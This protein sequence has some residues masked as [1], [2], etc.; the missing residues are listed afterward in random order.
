MYPLPPCA[1][2]P[3][4][5]LHL[6]SYE[7]KCRNFLH[8]FALDLFCRHYVRDESLNSRRQHYKTS[9]DLISAGCQDEG[10]GGFP[11]EPNDL[12]GLTSRHDAETEF[13]PAVHHN[14]N[15]NHH[16]NNHNYNYHK[17]AESG[18]QSTPHFRKLVVAELKHY[19]AHN[20]HGELATVE[21]ELKLSRSELLVVASK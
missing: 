7:Y 11:D 6:S 17:E 13:L 3:I 8:C 14:Y 2:L 4:G 18:C 9:F 1:C 12:P 16:H 19:L 15:N 21:S 10:Y 5:S 20:P